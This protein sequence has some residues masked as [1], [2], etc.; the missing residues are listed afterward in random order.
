M[1][2]TL[3]RQNGSAPAVTHTDR[4][5]AVMVRGLSKSYGRVPA[6]RDL[7]LDVSY[8]EIF[9]IL[10]PNGAGKSTTIEILEGHR[11]RDAGYARV[12]GE[13]PGVAG[14]SWR[15]KIGIVLQEASDAGMLTVS[16]TVRMFADCH[17]QARAPQEVLELVGLASLGNS[18]TDPI[19]WAAPAARRRHWHHQRAEPAISRRADDRLRSGSQT[20]LLGPHPLTGRRR[21]HHRVDHPLSR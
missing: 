21:H 2:R 1:S 13:D 19:R 18:S 6:V 5:S 20:T 3:R 4:S 12:L 7:D 17:A 10:G 15:A 16:E 8:G 11:K 14:R 9:A